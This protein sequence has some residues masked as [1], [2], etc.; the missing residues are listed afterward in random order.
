M[1]Q[2]EFYSIMPIL[3]LSLGIGDILL[4]WKDYFQRERLYL[5]HMITGVMIVEV[6]IRN[7]FLLFKELGSISQMTYNEFLARLVPPMFF[8][9]AAAAFTPDEDSD[10]RAYFN[11]RLPTVFSLLALFIASHWLV[12]F[13]INYTFYVRAAAVA[14]C[15]MMV[16][17]RNPNLIYVLLVLR[18]VIGVTDY[19][20][21]GI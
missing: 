2:E 10:I 16:I 3:L 13:E 18:V 11:R 7:Y 6:G 14:G 21:G 15:L 5:P 17:F 12:Q 4:H 1:S 20:R 8:L 19:L 9:L